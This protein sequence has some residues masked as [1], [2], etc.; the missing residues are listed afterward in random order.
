MLDEVGETHR[1][2]DAESGEPVRDVHVKQGEEIHLSYYERLDE[3]RGEGTKVYTGPITAE[4]ALGELTVRKAYLTERGY[5]ERKK[6]MLEQ[7]R[8]K[9][10]N[11]QDA[12]N[13][14][15]KHRYL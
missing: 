7:S 12:K 3:I 4:Q 14:V 11:V 8:R 2:V 13:V 15:V 6:K 5:F 9:P 10:S 1:W